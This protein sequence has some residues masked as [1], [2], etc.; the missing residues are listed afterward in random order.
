MNVPPLFVDL[1][2]ST[3]YTQIQ[4]FSEM[5]DSWAAAG[6]GNS[7]KQAVQQPKW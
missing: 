6:A 3:Y 1:T 2:S 5:E 7:G 4:I